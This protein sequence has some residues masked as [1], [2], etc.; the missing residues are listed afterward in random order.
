M[1]YRTQ[2]DKRDRDQFRT[3]P[4]RKEYEVYV[5]DENGNPVV[6]GV[7]NRY[8]EIQSHRES[9]ELSV[10][11]QRYALGDETALNQRVGEYVDV[12]DAPSSYAEF[13]D[14]FKRMESDFYSLPDGFRELFANNPAAYW[15]AL[16]TDEFGEKINQYFASVTQ[17]QIGV[18]GNNNVNNNSNSISGNGGTVDEQKSE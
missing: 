13:V 4:G 5:A 17:R 10:L 7:R 14:Q 8:D 1:K 2:F 11:L 12:T 3:N 15:K 18:S 6:S 16:G 9:V